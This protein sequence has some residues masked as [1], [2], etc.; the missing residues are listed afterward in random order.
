MALV[1]TPVASAALAVILSLAAVGCG[2]AP[3]ASAHRP[4]IAGEGSLGVTD[5]PDDRFA[6]SLHRV[7]RDGGATAEREALLA[8]VVRRQ[9]AH[10]ARRF[11]S[12]HEARGTESV[13]GALALVRAG[14]ARREMIDADG[15]R[16]LAGALARVSQRGEEG[17]ALALS[18]LRSAALADGSPAKAEVDGHIAAIEGWMR[19]TRTGGPLQR[20]GA[21]ERAAV[22]RALIDPSDEALAAATAA[23]GAFVDRAIQYNFE[24]QQ[25]RQRPEREEAV[26][27]ARALESGAETLLA[28]YLRQGDAKRALEALDKTG[29]RRLVRPPLYERIRL[30]ATDDGAR[31]W[32][33]LAAVFAQH[34]ARGADGEDAPETSVDP[35]VI[36]AGLWGT[37]L[38]AYRRAPTS[39]DGGM[40]LARSLVSLGLSE[41]APLVVADGLGDKPNLGALS[42]AVGLV[43]AAVGDGAEA[44]D[45]DAARRTFAAAAPILAAAERPDTR[46]HVE[47][48]AARARFLM[49]SIEMRDGRLAAARPL[50]EA[51]AAAEPTVAAYNLL[52]LLERQAGDDRAAIAALG[53][54]LAS[55]DARLARLDVAETHALA[56][57]I[58]RDAG[59]GAE[60]KASLDAALAEA[61]AARQARGQP[62]ARARAERLLGRVLDDYGDRKGAARALDRAISAAA[63]DRAALGGAMLDAVAHAL[64]RKDLVAAR[65]AVRRGLDADAPEEDLVYA[66]LWLQLLERDARQP[67]DGTAE[68]ALRSTNRGAW[69]SKLASW[70]TGKLSDSDLARSAQSAA[71]RVELDFY[72]AMAKKVA[73]DPTADARLRAVAKSPVLELLEVQIARD[74]YAPRATTTLPGGVQLP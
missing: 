60:A 18:R 23:V 56:F 34:A 11:A 58:R 7:L 73:G 30:A 20:L 35:S 17:R 72:T 63:D 33:V 74:L 9:L 44:D 41:A 19:E 39:F 14:E 40:L 42:A 59:A 47:P 54:A 21:E 32:Q 5:V 61:L 26:E 69:T 10:A 1:R 15:D 2:A 22:G 67:S 64:A 70:A 3:A 68:R 6:E 62:A 48:T 65:A 49:A 43:M 37:S 50:L 45:L 46:G 57:E 25:T 66:G 71:Q 12:G 31:D 55:P 13:L 24:L 16:A 27:A 53:K 51:A 36:S 8:G 4:A 52:A 29:A 28:L 38:E